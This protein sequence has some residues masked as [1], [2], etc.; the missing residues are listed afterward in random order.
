M[1]TKMKHLL[2]YIGF[3]LLLCGCWNPTY[4]AFR[5]LENTQF[6]NTLELITAKKAISFI[7]SSQLDSLKEMFPSEI[8]KSAK[9]SDWED[10]MVNGRKAIESNNMPPDSLVEISNT[11]NINNGVK[12]IFAKL[13]FPFII[14]DVGS[15]KM[16]INLITSQG[17]L[18][19][20]NVGE[21]PFGMR[22]IEPNHNES[23]LDQHSVKY[24]SINWFRIW[25]GSGFEKND[26]GDRF[27]YY[28]VSGDKQKIDKLKIDRELT[29]FFYLINSTKPDSIDFK[30]IEDK[31]TGNPEYIYLRFKFNNSPYNRFG[32]FSIYHH[33]KDEPG[34]TE[35]MSKY[36]TIKHSDKTRYLYSVK[37]NP[38]MVELLKKITY[39]RYDKYFE[40]RWM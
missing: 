5:E 35:P 4:Q 3:T 38:K 9:D 13:S 23:H 26:Y 22:F 20:L 33:L 14:S 37:K 39:N 17:K 15:Q 18:Y 1:N 24:E 25:Y 10:I 11:I 40:R 27:G 32:E 7:E 29:E 31:S 21:H 2:S 34:K 19:G 12:Q 16:Y 36:I 8:L 28:A 30:Y 6:E